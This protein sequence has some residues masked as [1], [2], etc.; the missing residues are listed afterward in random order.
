[1][2]TASEK[3][4]LITKWVGDD[5]REFLSLKHDGLRYR[6]LQKTGCL[7]TA[8]GSDNE[9]IQPEGLPNYPSS[10][11]LVLGKYAATEREE[12]KAQGADNFEEEEKEFK[13][14]NKLEEREQSIF[15]IFIC[16]LL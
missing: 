7:I 2:F 14:I 3:R 1:M 6:L 15:D 11:A 10:G 4:T 9:L 16:N 8:D 5:Y 12:N 13:V